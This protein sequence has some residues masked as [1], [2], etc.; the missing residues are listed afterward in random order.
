MTNQDLEII[1]QAIQE[2]KSISFEYNKPNKVNG[3]RVGNPY[4]IYWNDDETKQYLDLHQL[5]GVSDSVSENKAIFPHWTTLETDFISNVKIMA[6]A[7]QP[8]AD[9]KRYAERF[10]IANIKI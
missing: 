8:V 5:S 2:K 7:F 9:Y 10:I 3:I 6:D 1:K 4:V